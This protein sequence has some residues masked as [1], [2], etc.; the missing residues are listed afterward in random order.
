MTDR[1]REYGTPAWMQW[2][3]AERRRWLGDVVA[4]I[5]D[6]RQDGQVKLFVHKLL[7]ANPRH[8]DNLDACGRVKQL[9]ERG[10]RD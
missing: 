4:D 2:I 7:Q 10:L 1:N 8:C 9:R 5:D 6:I 3:A